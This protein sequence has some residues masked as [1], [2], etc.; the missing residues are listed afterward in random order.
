MLTDDAK[1]FVKS[2][3]EDIDECEALRDEANAETDKA[4][5]ARLNMKL[6]AKLQSVVQRI[7]KLQKLAPDVWEEALQASIFKDKEDASR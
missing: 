4:A 3:M 1:E 5:A 6:G 7:P 2:L